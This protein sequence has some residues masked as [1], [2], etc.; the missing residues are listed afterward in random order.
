MKTGDILYLVMNHK[1]LLARIIGF[2]CG[3]SLMKH[4]VQNV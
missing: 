4:T 3:E 2:T 1:L